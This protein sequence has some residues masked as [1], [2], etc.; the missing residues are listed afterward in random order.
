VPLPRLVRT[1]S[2]RLTLFYAGMFCLS[3]LILFGVIYWFALGLMGQQIDATVANEIAEI[4]AAAGDRDIVGLGEEVQLMTERAPGFYYLLQNR[5]GE[6]LAGNLPALQPVVG[7][8]ELSADTPRG[9][10]RLSGLRGQGVTLPDEGYLFVGVSTFELKELQEIVTKSFLW[11]LL[12]T[13]ILA[14]LGGGL[15][16]LRVLRKV[17]EVARTSREI[18]GGDFQRRIPVSGTDDEFD[19]LATSL[20]AMLDRIQNL[21]EDVHQVSNDIAHDLRTPISRMRQRIEHALRS[22]ATIDGMRQAMDETLTDVDGVLQTFGALLRI[23]QIESGSRKSAFAEVDLSLV[24]QRIADAYE[25]VAGERGQRLFASV[26]PGLWVRGDRELLTQL[27][28]NLVENAIQHSPTGASITVAAG[29]RSDS[30][31]VAI[32]DNGPGIP[33]PSRQKVFQRFFRLEESRTTPGNGLGLSLVAAIAALHDVAV[34]LDDNHPGLR[35]RMGFARLPR[36]DQ[37]RAVETLA[38]RLDDGKPAAV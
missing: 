29:G 16:S 18:I 13:S 25:P 5:S 4:R 7:V 11:G 10:G 12:A 19:R 14:L 36:P 20:N 22:A 21:M 6:V 37:V 24:L 23:A 35:V 30:I 2:F 38:S 31:E 26:V 15:V 17:E 33:P 27:F 1:S 9:R 3:F 32:E 34:M 28:A 8:R